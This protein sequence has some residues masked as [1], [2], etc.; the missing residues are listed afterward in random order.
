LKKICKVLVVEDDSD[1]R[2][3]LSGTFADQGYHFMLA[4]N[5]A[6]MRAALATGRDIDIV[7]VDLH[8]P[9]GIDGL[10]L[11]QEAA[12]QGLPVIMVSGDHS[13]LDEIENSG[14]RH[15]MKPYRLSS[16]LELVAETLKVTKADCER[17]QGT[18]TDCNL[19]L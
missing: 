15:I 3:L 9:G 11:A 19:V 6:E 14:H 5:A 2:E 8:L 13:R 7:V 17:Q 12:V 10:L 18:G 1:I 16:L 4:A